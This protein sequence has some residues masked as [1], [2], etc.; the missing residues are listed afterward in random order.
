MTGSEARLN[1]SD[2]ENIMI[3]KKCSKCGEE[4]PLND[5]S[6]HRASKDGLRPYC[7]IC[8]A[9]Y[10]KG[11]CQLN[12][13]KRS[14]SQK[15]Y[16]N[17]NKQRI[18]E[19][20]K[21]YAE[22]NKERIALTKSAY[23]KKRWKCLSYEDRKLRYK[24]KAAQHA[25][26]WQRYYAANKD[27]ISKATREYRKTEKGKNLHNKYNHKRRAMISTTIIEDF[28]HKEIFE[29]DGYICQL[30]GRKTRP[31]WNH[32]HPLYPNLDHIIPLS[33]G[34]PHTKQNVQCLCRHCNMK[35]KNTCV[36]DQFRLFG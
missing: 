23:D 6:R 7:K 8:Q 19:R 33:L 16:R 5:F 28:W 27:K 22:I 18:S 24:L 4:K 34:G 14:I 30:C 12:F 17:A 3:T 20:D 31:D 9:I 29:R 26:R 21:I 32:N 36:G 13:D 11:Y 10:D 25:E 15:A 1:E 35:K 2:F